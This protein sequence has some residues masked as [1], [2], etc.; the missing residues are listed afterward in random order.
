MGH[1]ENVPPTGGPRRG[2]LVTPREVNSSPH[3]AGDTWRQGFC[4]ASTRP[5]SQPPP[6]VRQPVVC[7]LVALSGTAP[8]DLLPG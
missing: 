2:A 5:L 6:G 3:Q 4:P 7:H 8:R 1:M